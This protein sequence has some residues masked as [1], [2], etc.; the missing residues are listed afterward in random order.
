MKLIS[1]NIKWPVEM[2]MRERINQAALF[3]TWRGAWI[4]IMEDANR[5]ENVPIWGSVAMP[6]QITVEETQSCEGCRE[7]FA[8]G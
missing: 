1:K 8:A 7:A 5:L 4:F 3:E 6:V 2:A